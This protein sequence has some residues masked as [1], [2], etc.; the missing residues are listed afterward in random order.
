MTDGFLTQTFARSFRCGDAMRAYEYFGAHRVGDK[1]V[2]RVWAP[3]ADWVSVCGDF[4]DWNTDQLPMRGLEG[5]IWELWLPA[6]RVE[7]RARYKYFIR[8]GQQELYKADPYA[9]LCEDS[10]QM[11]SVICDVDAYLWRDE[12]WL[13][14]RRGQGCRTDAMQKP[15]N[16]YELHAGSWRRHAD[17]R[18]YSYREL[19]AD[20]VTYVKQMGYTHVQL[21]SV[22]EPECDRWESRA[23][24]HYATA[25]RY[26]EPT[27]LMS[28]V[29][30][31][32]EAGIGVILDWDPICFSRNAYGLYEFD[33]QP[34]YEVARNERADGAC[35]A[36]C[37]FDTD[38]GEVQSFLLSNALF[39]IEKFHVD[40]LFVD[41]PSAAIGFFKSLDQRLLQTHPDVMMI[42]GERLSPDGAGGEIGFCM[43]WD[44][45]WQSESLALLSKEPLFGTR[46]IP[47][48]GGASR[49]LLPLSHDLFDADRSSLLG[50]IPGDYSQRLATVRTFLTYMMTQPGKKLSFMGCEIGQRGAWDPAKEPEWQLLDCEM[51]AKLQLFVAALN[52]LY[53]EQSPLWEC[54][55]ESKGFE[56][57]EADGGLLIY[58]RRNTDEEACTVV[59]NLS[60]AE[61]DNH[62]LPV[63]EQGVYCELINSD[64][65]IYGGRDRVNREPLIAEPV[66]DGGAILQLRIAPMSATVL[67]RV[68]GIR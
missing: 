43:E 46:R 1:L 37:R 48:G 22:C 62:G 13:D 32:H 12:G 67:R 44:R 20:L 52:Q 11:A 8:N 21:M 66:G 27:D 33:G 57:I 5:G 68:D 6:D 16:V 65:A 4:T 2:F 23:V 17:K 7:V 34:L 38:K 49:T 54:D 58:R 53:L 9:L 19:A 51:H 31:M 47:T 39:W 35:P 3:H 50:S 24:G 63:G 28:L 25:A 18:P 60:A 15:I 59:I 42:A 30:T 61:Y 36:T 55:D 64:A 56:P 40:G 29:D 10:P 14:Y 41:F 26:G 45:G